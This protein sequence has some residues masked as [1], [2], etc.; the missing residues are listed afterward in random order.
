VDSC[1]SRDNRW[2]LENIF[3]WERYVENSYTTFISFLIIIAFNRKERRLIFFS[4][5]WSIQLTCMMNK[6]EKWFGKMFV[7]FILSCLKDTIYDWFLFKWR[8][9]K[10]N[11]S[12]FF[13]SSY[14]FIRLFALFSLYLYLSH[15]FYC[16]PCNHIVYRYAI[17]DSFDMY[18]LCLCVNL[19]LG[20]GV[21]IYSYYFVTCHYTL[22]FFCCRSSFLH[23]VIKWVSLYVCLCVC[24]SETLL[25]IH[26]H[27]YTHG[28]IEVEVC[29]CLL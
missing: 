16:C 25:R 24:V 9:R 11:T 5:K 1:F 3:H 7:S 26:T 18:Y 2:Y 15:L 19:N 4:S 20:C 10:N 12:V 6:I 21:W 14:F 13:F 8:R 27:T 17:F 23:T 29:C 28:Q 22:T